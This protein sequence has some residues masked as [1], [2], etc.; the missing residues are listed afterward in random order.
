MNFQY[1]NKKG[2]FFVPNSSLEW[3]HSHAALPTSIDLGDNLIRTYFSSRDKNNKAHI[4]F[5]E[6]DSASLRVTYKSQ[7]PVICPGEYGLFDDHGVQA[8]SV[9][10]NGD[11]IYLY[12]LGWNPGA[13]NPL[14][15]TAIGLAIST[16]GGVSFKKYSKA[17]IM[18]RSK[19][20]PWMVSGGTVIKESNNWK[21]YYLSGQKMSFI[22]DEIISYYDIKLAT[23]SDGLHWDREGV[24]CLN[25]NF[26]E[27]NI[28]RMT[29]FLEN[30]IYRA[31][32][33]V[34]KKGNNYR[35]GYAESFDGIVWNRL[36]H[37]VKI[38]PSKSGWD[39]KSLDKVEVLNLN[40]KKI[41]LYNG[42]DFGKDGI[43]IAEL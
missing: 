16:D 42:N 13:K 26:D 41:M 17:P 10:R 43:G 40:N 18:Q 19:Y 21:M 20:D 5:F 34:K 8:T 15:Y 6:W 24:V 1:W 38:E 37:L 7:K 39:S 11:D 33:P 27:T 14:F 28:S 29:I 22:N 3:Q 12:Y 30:N 35:I 23:S 36:D 4:G 32:Y 9:I 25:L 2:L 31:W